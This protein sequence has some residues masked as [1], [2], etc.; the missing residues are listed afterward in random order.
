M[1]SS[2]FSLASLYALISDSLIFCNLPLSSIILSLI[3]LYLLFWRNSN[4]SKA[5]SAFA[6][7]SSIASWF[8]LYL[9]RIMKYCSSSSLFSS[10]ISV[11]IL[12][13]Y[14]AFSSDKN[15]LLESAIILFNFSSSNYFSYITF[16]ASWC[17]Y[18]LLCNNYSEFIKSF[19]KSLFSVRIISYFLLIAASYHLDNITK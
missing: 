8:A 4:Y 6:R 14:S 12:L 16:S 13:N 10:E 2:F 5:Y 1:F 3:S 9:V 11:I 15:I 17:S 7:A 19:L 18:S